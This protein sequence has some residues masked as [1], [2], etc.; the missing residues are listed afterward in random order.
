MI[1]SFNS[2]FDLVCYYI[3]NWVNAR[4]DPRRNALSRCEQCTFIQSGL[5]R[6]NFFFK[7]IYLLRYLYIV[8][9]IHWLLTK[10]FPI[11]ECDIQ[12]FGNEW[13]KWISRSKIFF[14]E[15]RWNMVFHGCI[16][17]RKE[18]EK[19]PENSPNYIENSQN[20]Y[21]HEF[22]WPPPSAI[23]VRTFTCASNPLFHSLILLQG[24][25]AGSAKR[26]KHIRI[27][28]SSSEHFHR[29][30]RYILGCF[31]VRSY[32]IKFIMNLSYPIQISF[33]FYAID[34]Q[35]V[36]KTYPISGSFFISV[37]ANRKMENLFF[38]HKKKK[39]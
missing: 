27:G 24:Q 33:T 17:N 21:F 16:F 12:F 36:T 39:T 19:P 2:K 15:F 30:Y 22:H 9:I 7:L 34:F 18:P 25:T 20:S 29:F 35:E 5:F 8:A 23:R 10:E 26:T 11:L 6:L 3:T 38:N 1:I 28:D 4:C 31:R 32:S 13:W 14:T 37:F